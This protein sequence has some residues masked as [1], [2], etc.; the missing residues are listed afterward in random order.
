MHWTGWIVALLM[1]VNGGWMAFD[2]ARALVVGDYVTPRTGQHAGQLGPWT[3]VVRASG[4]E[5]RSP[6][7]KTIFLV[8]GTAVLCVIVAFVLR[9]DWSWFAMVL[10][11]ALS[12]W[13]L[14]FGTL[15]DLVVLLLLLTT[16]LR[17]LRG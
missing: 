4:I 2:G 11:A 12:I 16:P 6:L 3:H 10:A 14:P 8:Y 9:A 13:Y 17:H 1:F 15:I 7:M 5:P